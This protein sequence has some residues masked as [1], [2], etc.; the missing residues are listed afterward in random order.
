MS[1]DTYNTEPLNPNWHPSIQ[2]LV[3]YQAA[4]YANVAAIASQAWKYI[5]QRK[6]NIITL[7]YILAQYGTLCELILTFILEVDETVATS[8]KYLPLQELVFKACFSGEP[9]LLHIEI[10]KSWQP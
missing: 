4:N 9:M 6:F 7:L 3:D 8:T 5:F 10:A 2:A 1:D